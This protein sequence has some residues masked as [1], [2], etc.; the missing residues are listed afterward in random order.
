LKQNINS[1]Q[2]LEDN[3]MKKQLQFLLP[4]I[5]QN[6]SRKNLMFLQCKVSE[7]KMTM[8]AANMFL[9]KRTTIY[10][11]LGDGEYYLALDDV[12]TA[13]K[14][15]NSKNFAEFTSEGIKIGNVLIKF[16]EN[17]FHYPNLEKL[18]NLPTEP[19]DCIG[20][21]DFNVLNALK[22]AP[23]KS[24]KFSFS[25]KEGPITVTFC[26]KPDYKVII[27]PVRINW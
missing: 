15:L 8:T 20:L 3:K 7:G 5:G 21:S 22:H 27:M 11:E 6:E 2:I 23:C 4:A 16:S 1:K 10:T 24:A 18:F 25:G 14:M 19:V 13:I 12:K 17:D 26:G 9:I